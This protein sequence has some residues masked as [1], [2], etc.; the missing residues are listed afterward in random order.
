MLPFGCGWIVFASPDRNTETE[1]E[2]SKNIFSSYLR[3][4]ALCI[5]HG[6]VI[7]YMYRYRQRVHGWLMMSGNSLDWKAIRGVC[8]CVTVACVISN[9]CWIYLCSLGRTNFGLSCARPMAGAILNQTS[10]KIMGHR[11]T[12]RRDHV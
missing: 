8:M 5:L 10:K 7:H 3:C 4:C 9:V 1:N 6:C 12:N 11:T 2:K